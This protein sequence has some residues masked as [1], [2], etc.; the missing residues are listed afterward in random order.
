MSASVYHS[1]SPS[2]DEEITE[3]D[4]KPKPKPTIESTDVFNE[5]LSKVGTFR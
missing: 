3:I 2:E 4:E 1:L 5:I